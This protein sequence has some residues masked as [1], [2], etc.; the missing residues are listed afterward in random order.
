MHWKLCWKYSLNI[1]LNIQ[2][3]E[4]HCNSQMGRSAVNPFTAHHWDFL[5]CYVFRLACFAW[6]FPS[7]VFLFFFYLVM[8]FS[9]SCGLLSFLKPIS[10]KQRGNWTRGIADCALVRTPW[11]HR[12]FGLG[13]CPLDVW[14]CEEGTRVGCG[15]RDNTIA[16]LPTGICT[17][18]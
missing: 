7:H 8:W 6:F 4:S 11:S 14:P 18:G 5:P 15:V 10:H 1:D 9:L 12:A 17:F 3:L 16:V 2:N 13:T